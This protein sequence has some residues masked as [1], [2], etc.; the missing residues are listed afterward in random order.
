[1]K[2][3][4]QEEQDEHDRVKAKFSILIVVVDEVCE[5]IYMPL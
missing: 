4:K 3:G 2:G 1:M 5:G